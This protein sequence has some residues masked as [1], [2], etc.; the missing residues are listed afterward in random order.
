MNLIGLELGQTTEPS[1]LSVFTRLDFPATPLPELPPTPEPY[2]PET[3]KPVTINW[4]EMGLPNPNDV[5]LQR[6][7]QLSPR[8]V[9]DASWDLPE[10][11][12][13]APKVKM[14]RR[15]LC[16]S[17]KQ[18]PKG[19]SYVKIVDTV[20]TVCGNPMLQVEQ[21]TGAIRPPTLVVG[22]RLGAPVLNMFLTAKVPANLVA[23]IPTGGERIHQDEEREWLWYVP[24]HVL[25]NTLLVLMQSQRFDAPKTLVDKER[26]IDLAPVLQKQ[27][28]D[29]RRKMQKA[30]DEV[31]GEE[32]TVPFDVLM[33]CTYAAYWGE[34]GGRTPR[35]W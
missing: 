24:N 10:D 26:K 25:V 30:K 29:Y 12:E 31:S 33:C 15:Y 18:W 23:I 28:H 6:H 16:R 11:L 22:T 13:Q 14:Q 17:L 3:P 2:G 7:K 5:L 8:I 4:D 19:T 35:A 32:E 1:A 20:R 27:M 21:A 34:R 9:G